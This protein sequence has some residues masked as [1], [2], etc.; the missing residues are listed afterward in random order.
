MFRFK[1]RVVVCSAATV[2]IACIVYHINQL[3][4][5]KQTVDEC[6]TQGNINQC[7]VIISFTSEAQEIMILLKSRKPRRLENVPPELYPAPP[8][9]NKVTWAKIGNLIVQNEKH[10]CSNVP[11]DRW[12]SLR[13]DGSGFSKLLKKLRQANIFSEGFSSFFASI[14][15]VCCR[16]L[17]IKFN[18]VCGYTQ[19]D[20]IS[21]LIPPTSVIHGV[22]QPHGHNGRVLKISTLAASFVTAL[23]NAKVHKF[24]H[25][26][27]LTFEEHHMLPYFDCRM[28]NYGSREEALM[29]LLWRAA[30]CG[31]NGISDA[32]HHQ[33]YSSKVVKGLPTGKK[34]QWLAQQKLLPLSLHQAHGIY[35]VRVRRRHEG[36]NPLTKQ[37]NISLR[38]TIERVPENLLMLAHDDRLFLPDDTLLDLSIN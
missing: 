36:V 32:V 26:E 28:G 25:A 33:K 18:G 34:L 38:N 3:K 30:D 2:G 14:M 35:F 20:E 12:I 21:I 19:S 22:H 6:S 27:N 29:L 23:F 5:N 4:T 15:Q 11:G 1:E 8:F 31:V 24:C 9:I 16:E 7:N 10:T 17:M 37:V 13:L